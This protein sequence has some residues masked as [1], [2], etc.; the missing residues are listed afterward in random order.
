MDGSLQFNDKLTGQRRHSRGLWRKLASFGLRSEAEARA[1]DEQTCHRYHP[2]SIDPTWD[3]VARS[4]GS[5]TM[6]CRL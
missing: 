5:K 4:G 3:G 6:F 2:F 1:R